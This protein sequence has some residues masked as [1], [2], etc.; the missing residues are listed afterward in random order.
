[1]QKFTLLLCSASAI[2]AL[3]IGLSSCKDDEPFVKPNLSVASKTV[4]FAEGGGTL[5]VEVVLDKGAPADITIEY[6]LGGTALSPADYSIVGKEG[7]VEIAKGATSG[8]ISIQ[9]VSD[10]IYEGNE[11]IEISLE[12]VDSDDV[13]I[14]N[15]DETIVTITDDDTQIKT[16]L[17]SVESAKESDGII[18]VQVVL[19]VA[20]AADATIQYSVSGTAR[21][22]VTAVAANPDLPAD[23]AVTG[24]TP[25]QLVIKAGQTTGIIKLRLYPDLFLEDNNPATDP[26]DPE[27][28]KVKITSASN[29]IDITTNSEV[30]IGLEQEDGMLVLL[31]WP[32]SVTAQY[33][34]M[35]LLLRVGQN[36]STWDR[37]LTGSVRERFV[38]PELIFLPKVVSFPAYGLSYVYYDGTLDPLEFEV[39]FV[40]F[41]D[42]V[43]EADA[44]TE[45][46]TGT[47]TAVHKNKWTDAATTK[48][49]QT[50]KK[51]NGAFA[52]FSA[53]TPAATGSRKKT[54]STSK[55][56]KELKSYKPVRQR[57]F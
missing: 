42:G 39:V 18:E 45:S 21:D 20:A 19:S 44:D 40:D 28:I 3:G 54:Y 31:V 2:M 24:K 49:V 41:V 11:T 50:F 46:F 56:L 22:S 5:E 14:T 1:M 48:V 37:I 25:G 33:A 23:Y 32:D 9:I 55:I 15:D 6:D 10:A 17:S 47:Y 52:E 57:T 30:E 12:D 34:D 29:G 43:F 26:F 35:D 4:S 27:T 51:V 53:I 16:S 7:E 36:I 8:T 13:V 38:G